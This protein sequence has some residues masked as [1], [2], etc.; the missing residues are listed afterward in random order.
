MK[1]DISLAPLRV[2][3]AEFV[4][5]LLLSPG[6]LK[7]VGDRGV[8][9]LEQAK[10]HIE[11]YFLAPQQ[12]HGFGYFVVRSADHQPAAMVGLKQR[13]F[14]DYPDLGFACLPE[15]YRTGIT[16][17]ACQKL[18]AMAKRDYG[19]EIVEAFTDAKNKASASLLGKLGFSGKG[20]ITHPDSGE[21]LLLF[22]IEL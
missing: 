22:R 10:R 3:D 15:Y 18:L 6:Y 20:S 21:D 12:E 2:A 1:T 4:L 14:M 13:E 7:Y 5:E 16:Y 17:T 19:M 11:S 8:S 9:N